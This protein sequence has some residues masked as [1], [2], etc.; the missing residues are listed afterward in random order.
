MRMHHLWVENPP[1][2][3]KQKFSLEDIINILFMYL[4]AP[5]IVQSFKKTLTADPEL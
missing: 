2:A 5:F 3:P 1:F 4:L